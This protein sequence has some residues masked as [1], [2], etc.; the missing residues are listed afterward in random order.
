MPPLQI[1]GIHRIP[2]GHIA[3][4]QELKACVLHH[5]QEHKRNPWRVFSKDIT[6]KKKKKEKISILCITV[7]WHWTGVLAGLMKPK[8]TPTPAAPSIAISPRSVLQEHLKWQ[9][10]GRGHWLGSLFM[11]LATFQVNLCFFHHEHVSC[12]LALCHI[13]TWL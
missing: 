2:I 11:A 9:V 12:Y 5:E 7:M 1:F 3:G 6:A 10:S 4:R 8:P 13:R